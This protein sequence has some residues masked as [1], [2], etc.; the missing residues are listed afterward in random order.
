MHGAKHGSVSAGGTDIGDI[1]HKLALVNLA[2]NALAEICR[3]ALHLLAH[4]GVLVGGVASAGVHYAQGIAAGGKIEVN[5]LD[6]GLCG[7][8]EIYL[9]KRAD[10]ACHLVEQ[11]AGLAEEFVLRRLRYLRYFNVADLSVVKQMVY[12]SSE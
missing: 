7:V 12:Y 10:G 5:L 4:G 2:Q 11:T 6:N 3:N 1:L 8:G 9:D